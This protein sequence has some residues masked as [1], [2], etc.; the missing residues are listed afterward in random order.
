MPNDFSGFPMQIAG[1][2]GTPTGELGKPFYTG[3]AHDELIARYVNAEGETAT[4]YIGYFPSQNQQKELVDYRYNWLYDGAEPVRFPSSSPA[5]SMM[6]NRVQTGDRMVSVFFSYD[7]NGRNI[8]DP[9]RA[10]L[11]SVIDAL[12]R[13]HNNGAIIIVIFDKDSMGFSNSQQ[14]FLRGVVTAVDKQLPRG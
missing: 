2:R 6:K 3:L 14:T 8:I 9:K 4:V 1:F 13:R 11:A 12:T 5:V 7:I 10:K